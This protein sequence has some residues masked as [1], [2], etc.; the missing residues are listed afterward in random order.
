MSTTETG[1]QFRDQVAD[2]LRAAG[3]QTTAEILEDHKR[4]D[5]LF[6][7]TTFGKRRRYALEAKNW[8]RPLDHG[9]LEHIFSAY[10]SLVFTHKIDE[11]L[12]VS[13][14]SIRSPAAKAFIRDTPGVSHLSFK[15][16]QES[17]M[18]FQEYLSTFV[19]NHD[20]NGL[21][22][23]FIS[24]VLE[25]GRLAEELV[26]DWIEEDEAE[27]IAI[28]ASYGMGKTSLAE[29]LCYK[30]A[31]RFLAGEPCR[32]PI[33]ISL[34]A[35]AREQSLEGLVGS[36]LAGSR[37]YVTSYTFPLFMHL[38]SIG[39]FLILLDGFDEMKH[40]MTWSEFQSTFDELNRLVAGR[41][42]VVLL[43]RPTAFL[44]E[45]E[46]Q[47]A[48]RGVRRI[49]SA[50]LRTPGAP[51]YAEVTLSPFSSSQIKD[52]IQRYLKHH[53]SRGNIV[54]GPDFIARRQREMEGQKDQGLI[55]RPVHARM[56]A[57]VA[58]D[59]LVD[60][61]GMSRF[62]LYDDFI[63]HLIKRELKKPGRGRLFKLNDRRSFASDLA[64]YLW[65]E[66]G[67][68]GVG[69]R[70]DELPDGLFEP[71]RPE[72]EDISSTK[73]DL[74][75]ASFLDQKHGGVYFFSHRSFQEFLVSEHIWNSI[76]ADARQPT[77][78]VRTLANCLTEEVFDFLIERN[79][80]SFFRSFFSCLNR[81]GEQFDP[82]RAGK[83]QDEE[84]SI[85]YENEYGEENEDEEGDAVVSVVGPQ[86]LP[87]EFFKMI[88]KSE[89]IRDMIVRK[90]KIHFSKIDAVVLIVHEF[91]KNDV[92]P[93][94]LAELTK[95]LI[96]KSENKPFI[97]LSCIFS[98]VTCANFFELPIR[99]IV[100][101]VVSLLFSRAESDLLNLR[102]DSIRQTRNDSLRDVLFSTV[103]AQ[104]GEDKEINMTIALSELL[105]QIFELTLF[106]ISVGKI[107]LGL[108]KK[109][110]MTFSEFF[111]QV[112]GS[113]KRTIRRFYEN[114]AEMGKRA[115][116]DP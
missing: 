5:V 116:R 9:D 97:I 103:S 54:E 73:R 18:G 81:F 42:K 62:T 61:L 2:L 11:L 52:F 112:G 76:T 43:G 72:G 53:Q 21:E 30:L 49:G 66:P 50:P 100:P 58:T 17:I 38:N 90:N 77:S 67:R 63:D 51:T 89:L 108:N 104:Y 6:E 80:E 13:P 106:P 87:L 39:R 68:S 36:L 37:P 110:T 114:D 10:A 25:D 74:L 109:C 44:S 115:R 33:L 45:S 56:L 105:S 28:I 46:R 98:Y 57:D 23:Y 111:S 82:D 47:Y 60:I 92:T 20:A 91:S 15:D 78:Y 64:W 95:L 29:H 35:I 102:A 113:S 107:E 86:T 12:I 75:S 22:D 55:S 88:S 24:P 8:K 70:L 1:D 14:Q 26:A 40:M 7:Q 3:Y 19:Y 34:G 65:S 83:S 59:P 99:S 101:W 4:V 71:Y 16:F 27:P 32:V 48:L 94:N 85:Y 69:C 31:T 84:N 96:Q 79:D 41:A 93:E